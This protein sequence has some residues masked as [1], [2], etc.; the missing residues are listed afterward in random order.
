[1]GLRAAGAASANHQPGESSRRHLGAKT[2][3]AA[4]LALVLAG[5]VPAAAQQAQDHLRIALND[6]IQTT[7]LYDDQKPETE[8]VSPSVYD[9]LMCYDRKAGQFTP[10]LASS[11][12]QVDDR[13]LEFA[14]RPDVKFHDGS[15]LTADD[16]AYTL[17]YVSNPASKLRFAPQENNLG[18]I[19]KAEKVD[20]HTVRVIAKKPTPLAMIRLAVFA[21]I[22]QAKAHAA[23]ANKGDYGRNPALGTG[24]YKVVS[25]DPGKG[26]ELAKNPDYKGTPCKPA[27][28]IG[29]VSVKAM[30]DSQTQT[31]ELMVGGL[32]VGRTQTK[33]EADAM[34]ANPELGIITI[35]D[36]IL[37]TLM[38][39]AVGR[40]GN[41][42]LTKLEVRQAIAMAV[43]VEAVA[44]SVMPGGDAIHRARALCVEIEIA[45]DVSVALPVFDPK[46]ARELLASAG[47]PN[48]FD[49]E[50]TTLPASN[51]LAD[52]LAGELRKVGIRATVDKASFTAYRQK[53]ADGKLQLSIGGL[54]IPASLDASTHTSYFFEE[55]PRNYT[56]DA[57]LTKLHRAGL[58]TLDLAA[59]KAIYRQIND[60]NLERLYLVPLVAAPDVFI[61]SK[62]V[63][64]DDTAVHP[65]GLTLFDLHWAK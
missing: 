9:T 41:V 65:E 38:I 30:P 62:N 34:A 11:W 64:Y 53:Q 19:E 2:M 16:V 31:A 46:K 24:P 57:E 58:V 22:V 36:Q 48:G 63:A 7:L 8:I 15:P 29:K 13:T 60:R 44:R 45:C 37:H 18:W 47:Y 33:D 1:M 26:I 17:N 3:S 56:G 40:S 5:G 42:A 12:K 51:A 49:T 14:L 25:Y 55:S 27:G 52:A 50:I 43:D 20:D 59:R 10:L 4:A 39:D 6:P 32:D 23:L 35:P 28:A 61:R 21:P 54:P